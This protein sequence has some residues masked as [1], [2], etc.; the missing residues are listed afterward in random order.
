MQKRLGFILSVC[1]LVGIVL[2]LAR[3]LAQPDFVVCV[4]GFSFLLLGIFF[5][6]E[7]VAK[8]QGR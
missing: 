2:P 6:I 7:S 8:R 1:G 5:T 3:V 4:V